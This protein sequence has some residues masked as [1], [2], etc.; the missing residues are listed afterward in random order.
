MD[1][2][3]YGA[4]ARQFF[5]VHA[6]MG[7]SVLRTERT[8]ARSAGNIVTGMLTA[9]SGAE[10]L[11]NAF[12]NLEHATKLGLGVA[13]G[14]SV[15]VAL[16]EALKKAKDE[17]YALNEEIRKVIGSASGPASYSSLDALEG[18][19]TSIREEQQK[20]QVELNNIFTSIASAIASKGTGIFHWGPGGGISAAVAEQIAER[21]RRSAA[22][23]QAEVDTMA[24]ITQ[25]MAE[26]ADL[27]YTRL[28]VSQQQAAIDKL[29]AEYTERRARLLVGPGQ[30]LEAIAQLDR[31]H[32]LQRENL[33][34]EHDLQNKATQEQVKQARMASNRLELEVQIRSE[35]G[36][37]NEEQARVVRLGDDRLESLKE[38]VRYTYDLYRNTAGRSV[39]ESLAA[40]IQ[41]E[42]ALAAL[43][44]ETLSRQ[45][46]LLSAIR[47]TRT[48]QQSLI[49]EQAQQ[50]V[51]SVATKYEELR[52]NE[53][54]YEA[55]RSRAWQQ[56]MAAPA[57]PRFG[58][59]YRPF[60]GTFAQRAAGLRALIDADFS[61]L[62][63]LSGLDFSGL[64]NLS[65]MTIIV[66]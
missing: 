64:H 66:Q 40:Q 58:E 44:A 57:A 41:Y 32:D 26:T 10:A 21:T 5:D 50:D 8:V 42:K 56:G 15:G 11:A 36:N 33:Q 51:K 17:A 3:T 38:E 13:V 53:R 60:E 62:A 23:H 4:D 46:A 9:Q 29:D 18:K 54:L 39:E 37:V 35:L 1:V 43:K 48:E 63:S 7:E 59:E 61:S 2:V 28:H 6:R 30:N 20:V 47:Q 22:L 65:G 49:M 19:L 12:L 27:E 14:V 34:Y 55:L 24:K 16:Y 25:K 45:K 31:L 52:A